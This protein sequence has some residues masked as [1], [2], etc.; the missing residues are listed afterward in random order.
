MLV[1]DYL[2]L[3]LTKRGPTHGRIWR[4]VRRVDEIASGARELGPRRRP[5]LSGRIVDTV[6][7]RQSGGDDEK[8]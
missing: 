1:H 8:T 5:D 2:S 6:E 7:Q 4:L 3:S